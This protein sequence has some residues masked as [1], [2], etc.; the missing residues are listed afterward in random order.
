MHVVSD[1]LESVWPVHG[2]VLVRDSTVYY[3]A[4]RSSYVDGGVR[5]GKLDLFDRPPTRG[6]GVLQPRSGNRRSPRLVQALSRP[7][8][9]AVGPRCPAYCPM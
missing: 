2:S 7:E 8:Q 9:T 4:G 5:M 3:A 1:R 6:E